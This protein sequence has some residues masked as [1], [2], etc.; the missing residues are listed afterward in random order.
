MLIER[1]LVFFKSVQYANDIWIFPNWCF[2]DIIYMSQV[3][4]GRIN[5]ISKLIDGGISLDTF[6]PLVFRSIVDSVIIKE[7]TRLT[8]KFK[9]DAQKTIVATIKW[10][11]KYQV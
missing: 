2:I 6:V 10:E 8:F 3:M 4:K 11:K 9:I 5:D 1:L 7:R